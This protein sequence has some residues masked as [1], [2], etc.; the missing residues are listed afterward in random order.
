MAVVSHWLSGSHGNQMKHCYI[1]P[2]TTE[3]P[4]DSPTIYQ[5]PKPGQ[6]PCMRISQQAQ[7]KYK[8]AHM[9]VCACL[10]ERKGRKQR[11]IEVSLFLRSEAP[12]CPIFNFILF[13]RVSVISATP[14]AK[15]NYAQTITYFTPLR[16]TLRENP[17]KTYCYWSM[18]VQR[19]FIILCCSIDMS[20][21]AGNHHDGYYRWNRPENIWGLVATSFQAD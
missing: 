3:N 7:V 5:F 18:Y 9:C 4:N 10:I 11:P 1:L 15:R 2:A 19:E 21:H 12:G 20:N 17:K 14:E 16:A 8:R 6:N 13:P